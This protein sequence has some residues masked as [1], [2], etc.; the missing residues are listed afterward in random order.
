MSQNRPELIG[1]FGVGFYASFMVAD[2]VTVLS[3]QAGDKADGRANGKAT[4]RASSP[5]SRPRRKPA[6]PMS[7]FT[8]ARTPKNFSHGWEIRDIVKRYSDFIDHPIVLDH[9]RKKRTGR[10]R[11]KEEVVNSRQAIWLRPKSEVKE[12]EYN[13]FY[14]QLHAR[15]RRPAQDHPRGGRGDDGIPRA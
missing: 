1:Q 3:R 13:A 10:P 5:S 9:R 6:A 11:P 4:A 15:F 7:S 2:R 8:C 12:E 14:K